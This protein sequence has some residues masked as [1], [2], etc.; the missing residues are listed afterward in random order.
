MASTIIS[1]AA[2]INL[3]CSEMAKNELA[4]SVKPR[5]V[6]ALKRTCMRQI[7]LVI[8]LLAAP[9]SR[10]DIWCTVTDYGVSENSGSITMHGIL[11]SASGASSG[12]KSWINL[13]RTSDASAAKT[14]MTIIL[15][16]L[17]MG[18]SLRVYVAATSCGGVPDWTV[19]SILHVQVNYQGT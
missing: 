16:A 5:E 4:A 11:T 1:K 6:I 19:D 3:L 7:L 9:A 14:R 18:R 8:A 12:Y 10:A 2:R 13:G 15:T 17:A